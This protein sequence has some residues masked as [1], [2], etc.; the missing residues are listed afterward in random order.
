MR[1]AGYTPLDGS[2]PEAAADGEPPAQP[3][4]GAVGAPYAH[5]TAPLRRLADR[6]A[7]EVC[8]AL[9]AGA[10]VPDRVRAALPKLPAVMST[11]DR[12]AGAAERG[13]VDL[14]EAVVL[15][16]R[17]GQ[18]FD[19]VVLDVGAH[20]AAV[21]LDDP[22][23]R[24]RCDGGGL[25]LGARVRVRLAVADPAQRRVLFTLEES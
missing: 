17:V 6:Y 23:V 21:A 4:H 14:A 2:G 16:D 25:P 7:T 10:E 22:P 8:L 12:V 3:L 24:A 19:A 15:A 13:A 20:H 11:S 1:G 18:V 9:H 5:V